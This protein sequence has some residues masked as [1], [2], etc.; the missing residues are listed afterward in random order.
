[1]QE[2]VV[3]YYSVQNGGDGS[4]CPVF[5]ETERIALMDQD[6]MLEGWG[7]P[8]VNSLTIHGNNIIV[9]SIKTEKKFLEELKEM[10]EEVEEDDNDENEWTIKL[11][12]CITE[13]E[14]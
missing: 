3:I 14:A 8:C 12:K 13:L 7:E 11:R 2:K 5:M 9:D 10:L 6:L 4:A 1:M